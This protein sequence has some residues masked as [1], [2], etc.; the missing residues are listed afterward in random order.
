MIF[1]QETK[2]SW[3]KIREIHNKWII[4]YEYLEVEE[5]NSVGGLSC[6]GILRN[7]ESWTRKHP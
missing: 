5:K 2:C 1:I 4:K 6:C 3:D 7:L